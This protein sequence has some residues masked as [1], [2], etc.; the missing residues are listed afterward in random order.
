MTAIDQIAEFISIFA[1]WRRG[2]EASGRFSVGLRPRSDALVVVALD[3]EKANPVAVWPSGGGLTCD[4]QGNA[5][6]WRN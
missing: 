1:V 2:L 4:G 3:P 5:A 6:A